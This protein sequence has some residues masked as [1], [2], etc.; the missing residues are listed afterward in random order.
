MPLSGALVYNAKLVWQNGENDSAHL[1]GND[2]VGYNKTT[3]T[4]MGGY[5]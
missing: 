4:D 2:S 1:T 3:I 5:L